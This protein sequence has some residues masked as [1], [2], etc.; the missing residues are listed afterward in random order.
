MPKNFL[1]VTGDFVK[2]GGMDRANY[3]LADYLARQGEA[4]YLVAYRVD[5]SLLSYPNVTFWRV[6]KL[7]N[8]YVLSG[9]LLDYFG[10]WYARKITQMGGQVI[11]NGGSCCWG[12]ISWI[13]YIHAV[14][15]PNSS[16]N[17]SFLSNSFKNILG[18]LKRQ[19]AHQIFLASE[20][21]SLPV[22]KLFIANSEQ[23]KQMLSD[24]Y[25]I[26]PHK[27]HTVYLGVDPQIFYPEVSSKKIEIRKQLGWDEN[28]PIV[29]F[30]GDPSDLRKGFDTL[31]T[32]WQKLCVNPD[33]DANL[34]VIGSNKGLE[35]RQTYLSMDIASKHIQF[36]GF[37]SDVPTLLRAS[38]C[39][40]APTRYESYGLSVHE[41]LCSGIPAIVSKCSGVAERYPSALEKL[42]LPNPED[43]LDLAE[44]LHHWWEHRQSYKDLVLTLSENLRGYSWDNMAKNMLEKFEQHLV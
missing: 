6:P 31:L 33:W 8:S 39:L 32:A 5:A 2:T 25:A 40:V 28:K 19:I 44:R 38:D 9:F 1:I 34:V 14:Y 7:A 18:K 36:M 27:I 17:Q 16:S 30:I 13:H 24:K 35:F 43:S 41:A 37:R 23:T 22:A 29:A 20:Q 10:R 11:V 3:A 15:N 4:V 42:L 26:A 21:R 12:D